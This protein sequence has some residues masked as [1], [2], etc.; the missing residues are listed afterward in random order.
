MREKPM[1][2]FSKRLRGAALTIVA[3]ANVTAT[4]AHADSFN[5]AVLVPPA[6]L[7]V[8]ARQSGEAMLLHETVDGPA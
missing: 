1:N 7:P 2:S 3:G 6:E 8:S 5:N 4:T